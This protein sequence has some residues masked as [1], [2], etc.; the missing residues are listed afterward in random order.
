[1]D[2][3]K[4]MPLKLKREPL[5][6]AL[7]EVRFA[8]TSPPVMDLLPGL[9]Y[10]AFRSDDWHL[11]RLPIADIPPPIVE[12]DSVL[13]YMPKIR[14]ENN[15]YAIQVGDRVVSLSYRRPYPGWE[16]FS[17]KIRDLI[18]VLRDTNLIERLERFS[19]KYINLVELTQPPDLTCL[20]VAL[21][22][23]KYDLNTLPLQLRTEIRDD[24]FVQ[25][26]QIISPA[27]VS[28]PGEVS[29][30]CG[31]LLD[32]DTIRTMLPNESWP[33][34]EEH[35]EDLHL[36]SKRTFFHLLTSETIARLEPEYLGE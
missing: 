12:Q 7:W 15:G 30:L 19:F 32:I 28:L 16:A 6:E 22:L 26:I 31:V 18:G 9:L 35:L 27:E 21:R 2:N 11:V 33:D 25:I 3:V 8:T 5:L 4:K 36:A 29:R 1:M 24:N 14:L 23:G 20:D 13:R 17:Q 10:K 34:I